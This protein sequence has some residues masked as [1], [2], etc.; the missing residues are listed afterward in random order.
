MLLNLRCSAARASRSVLSNRSQVSPRSSPPAVCAYSQHC[1]T[2]CLILSLSPRC[3]CQ[4]LLSIFYPEDN[5]LH[6]ASESFQTWLPF[7]YVLHFTLRCTVRL[8]SLCFFYFHR[9]KLGRSFVDIKARRGPVFATGTM[10]I[11]VGEEGRFVCVARSYWSMLS[12]VKGHSHCWV[13]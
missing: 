13:T 1:Y 2:I 7:L 9:Q 8:R 3:R 12:T 5:I 4:T 11:L 10:S 6:P